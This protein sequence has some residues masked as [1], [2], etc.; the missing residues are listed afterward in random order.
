MDTLV[1][2][3]SNGMKAVTA[4]TNGN[5]AYMGVLVNAG[6]RDDGPGMDGLAHFVEHTIFKGTQ[7]R[8][9]RQVSDRMESV[10]GELN[11]YTTKENIMIYANSPAGYE[12]RGL[13]LLGDLIWN[14]NFPEHEVSLEK[15]VVLEEIHS[16]RDNASYA[17]F[18][19]FDEL[20]YASSPLAHNI[21]GYADTVK[22]LEP[23][24]TMRFLQRRFTPSSM[25]AY[26]VSPLKAEKGMR[27]IEKHFGSL[28]R[29]GERPLRAAPAEPAQFDERRDRGNHQANTV[30][31]CRI[32]GIND[33]RR[34]ALYL[35]TNILGGPGM[36][37]RLNTEL[38]ERRGLVYTI[39]CSSALYSDS[40]AFQVY[41]GCEPDDVEKCTRIAKRE[42]VRMAECRMSDRSFERARRQFCGQLLVAGDN[43]E[44]SAMTLAKSMMRYGFPLDSSHTAA[45]I[46]ELTADDLRDTAGSIAESPLSRLT[47]T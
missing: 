23:K 3:L 7:R 29:Q 12:D 30:M 24:D 40:G 36:N 31:G 39:E 13:E 47:L 27:M 10:G 18:D 26:C 2:T 16:Y 14:A 9:A 44:S 34:Y 5:V 45:R 38:R 17:V 41:F 28:T 19:E 21:L 1:S 37:S 8:R 42:I 4:Q 6:S 35:L 22:H 43:R 11:A 33:P 20:M 25:V 15:G 32:F 46:M